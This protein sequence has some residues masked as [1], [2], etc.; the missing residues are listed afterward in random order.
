M[1]DKRLLHLYENVSKDSIK[2]LMENIIKL[3][4]EDDENDSKEK[5]FKRVPIQLFVNSYGG[6]VYDCLGLIALMEQSKTPIHTYVYGYAMSAGLTIAVSGHKRYGSKYSTFM[7]HQASNN[8]GYAKLDIL[9]NR[10]DETRRL[11]ELK[12]SILISKTKWKQKDLDYVNER[13][14][15]WFMTAQEALQYGLIDEII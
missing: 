15:D 4:Y 2:P 11:Q 7:Y 3:N 6:T 10:V 5:N 14:K 13:Q 12:D 1:D 9:E 8:P